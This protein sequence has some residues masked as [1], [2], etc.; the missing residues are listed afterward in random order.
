MS[1]NIDELLKIA[2]LEKLKRETA[3]IAAPRWSFDML[4]KSVIA[5]CGVAGA[6]FAVWLNMPKILLE[7]VTVQRALVA[8]EKELVKQNSDYLQNRVTWNNEIAAKEALLQLLKIEIQSLQDVARKSMEQTPTTARSAQQNDAVKPRVFVQF[9]GGIKRNTIDGLRAA[10]AIEEF[11]APGAERISRGQSNEVRY[12]LNDPAE[13]GRAERVGALTEA[14]FKKV[15]CPLAA[16]PIKRMSL[17]GNKSAPIEVWLNH[18]CGEHS[19][20]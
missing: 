7:Q 18:S 3:V 12:F 1:A 20:G 10:I 5:V 14:Y 2:T 16:L 4:T 8:S 11:V 13:R 15:G 17:P 6:V 19:N 9:E